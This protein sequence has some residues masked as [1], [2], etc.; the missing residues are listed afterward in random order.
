MEWFRVEVGERDGAHP[1]A[2]L[3]HVAREAGLDGRRVGTI[4]VGPTWTFVEL[5]GGMP[6]RVFRDLDRTRFAG[7]PLS[8]SRVDS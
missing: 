7:R 8:L 1:G 4:D 2:I 6:E 3:A 5:P